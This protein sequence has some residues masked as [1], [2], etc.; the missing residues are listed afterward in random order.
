MTWFTLGDTAWLRGFIS[1]PGNGRQPTAI[2]TVEYPDGETRLDLT[3]PPGETAVIAACLSDPATGR[4]DM[5]LFWA[6][7]GAAEAC[8]QHGCARVVALVP[9]IPCARQDR[10]TPS[11]FELAARD[12]VVRLL[13]S[14]VLEAVITL[15]AKPELDRA[16][17]RCRI[18]APAA[19]DIARVVVDRLRT[20]DADIDVVM[21]PD[22][23]SA[24]F[25]AVFAAMLSRRQENLIKS[26]VS[27]EAVMLT[28]PPR[29]MP[30][31]GRQTLIVDDMYVSG[32][33]LLAAAS[34]AG[35]SGPVWAYISNFRPTATGRRRLEQLFALPSFRGL[36]VGSPQAGDSHAG[37]YPV[38]MAPIMDPVLGQELAMAGAH[39]GGAR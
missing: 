11:T 33:T 24:T 2:A 7:L 9:E 12:W 32:G 5:S 28:V 22:Q 6:L 21:A 20:L 19:S 31:G 34:I 39:A 27:A 13:N 36:L 25:A 15:H 30:L 4:F 23:G 3:T 18:V 1:R 35:R 38:A 8:W 17:H 10:P 26:R 16:T 29:V 14:S 37:I